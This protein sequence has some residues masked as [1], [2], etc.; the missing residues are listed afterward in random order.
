M[1]GGN[2]LLA[3]YQTNG[4]T[5]S[6]ASTTIN[7]TNGAN[8][9]LDGNVNVTMDAASSITNNTA[10]T[11]E[12]N[13][14][15]GLNGLTNGTGTFTSNGLIQNN[16]QS[17]L[18]VIEP[19]IF[20][21]NG[22]IQATNGQTRVLLSG[23]GFTTNFTNI[24]PGTTLTGGTYIVSAANSSIFTTLDFQTRSIA[25]IATG[26][27]VTLNGVNTTFNSLNA[28][29]TNNGT[30]GILGGRTFTPTAGTVTNTGSLTVGLTAGDGS[31]FTGA[32]TNSARNIDWHRH[33]HRRDHTLRRNAR[34]RQRL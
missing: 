32:V 14:L 9:A 18:L 2:T 13:S 22:T 23:G 20:T 34:A 29:T 16:A 3:F 25:T 15:S 11:T 30:F 4:S 26:T 31:K 21:N 19:A 8:V 24:D 1:S 27:T 5:V 33:H 17:S 7:F 28:L 10:F 12:I 6:L